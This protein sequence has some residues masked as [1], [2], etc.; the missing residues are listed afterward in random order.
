MPQA[1]DEQRE[2]MQQWFG[3]EIDDSGPSNFLAE[4]GWTFPGGICTP[5]VPS[6]QPSQY[7]LEC[8]YFLCDEWDY[9]YHGTQDMI[10]RNA[11]HYEIK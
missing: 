3:D 8:V 6:H 1:T 4:R 2:L 5:P 10:R 11:K 9:G 7:E